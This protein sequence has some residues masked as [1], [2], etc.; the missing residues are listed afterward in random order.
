MSRL[1]NSGSESMATSSAIDNQ[2]AIMTPPS[3]VLKHVKI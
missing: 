1:S 3:P 2:E